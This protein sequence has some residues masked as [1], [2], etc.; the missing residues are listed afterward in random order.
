MS[1]LWAIVGCAFILLGL[2]GGYYEFATL[3]LAVCVTLVA[4][5]CD[6]TA[7]R[8]RVLRLFDVWCVAFV[9]LFGSDVLLTLSDVRADFGIRIA[10]AAE[11]IIVAAFGASLLGYAGGS[12]LTPRRRQRP[13]ETLYADRRRQ[14]LALMCLSTLILSYIALA[15]SP[16]DL[17]IVRSA[18]NDTSVQGP[19]FIAVVAAMVVQAAL[20]A[21]AMTARRRDLSLAYPVAIAVLSIPILYGLGTRYFLGFFACGVLFYVAHVSQP[22]SNRRMAVFAGAV[23]LLT[24]VQGTMRVVRV[25]GF[26]ETGAGSVASMLARPETYVSSEGM[27]RVHAWVSG[28]RCSRN[29]DVPLN[30]RSCSIGGCRVRSGRRNPPWT[31]TGLR[32]RSWQIKR[33]VQ[34]TA[35]PAGSCCP[36]CS[37]SVRIWAS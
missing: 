36:R 30:T 2:A 5:A 18:R 22:L 7:R 29:E 1:S 10:S 26:G 14:R 37:T 25:V 19:A 9:Y 33:A 12:C 31:V 35:S 6:I 13:V 15:V 11:G 3:S 24:A 32:T 23:L 27:L 4:V 28:N 21:Q 20:T 34:G 16:S 17:L 8:P